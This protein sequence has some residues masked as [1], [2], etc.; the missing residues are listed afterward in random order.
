MNFALFLEL[1]ARSRP[2]ETALVDSRSSCI[3]TDALM[4]QQWRI[5][6]A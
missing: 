4:A 1:H 5:I 6:S 2:D 3:T